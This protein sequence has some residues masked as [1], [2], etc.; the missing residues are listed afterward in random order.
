MKNCP[1]CNSENI[2]KSHF[3]RK[4][5]D[6]RDP[7]KKD[8]KMGNYSWLNRGKTHGGHL[9]FIQTKFHRFGLATV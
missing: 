6:G 2:K 4:I 7:Q 5:E 9:F 1:K 8:D 3:I